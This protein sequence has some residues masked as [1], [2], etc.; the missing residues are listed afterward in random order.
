MVELKIESVNLFWWAVTSTLPILAALFF[1]ARAIVRLTRGM[2]ELK[3]EVKQLSLRP[4]I[5]KSLTEVYEAG[6][7]NVTSGVLI[8]FLHASYKHVC[9]AVSAIVEGAVHE[10]GQ[11]ARHVE[12]K[13]Q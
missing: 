11:G 3:A 13:T 2:T 1:L 10:T 8:D 12:A 7:K 6:V 5:Y 9:D 4:N